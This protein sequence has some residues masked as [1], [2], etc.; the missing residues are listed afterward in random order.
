MEGREC[1][2]EWAKNTREGEVEGLSAGR[3][4]MM[5]TLHGSYQNSCTTQQLHAR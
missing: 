4:G 3:S 5:C 1:I 2:G